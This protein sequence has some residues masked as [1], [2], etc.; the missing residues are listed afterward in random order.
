[1]INCIN[2]HGEITLMKLQL[3][4]GLFSNLNKI[5]NNK[6]INRDFEYIEIDDDSRQIIEKIYV[7]NRRWKNTPSKWCINTEKTI[8]FIQ[9]DYASSS[10]VR[11]PKDESYEEDLFVWNGGYGIISVYCEHS[12]PE[13]MVGVNILF[14]D[15]K[16]KPNISEEELKDLLKSSMGVYEYWSQIDYRIKRKMQEIETLKKMPFR[17]LYSEFSETFKE[18]LDS[19]HEV[20]NV[21]MKFRRMCLEYYASNQSLSDLRLKSDKDSFYLIDSILWLYLHKDDSLKTLKENWKKITN[22]DLVRKIKYTKEAWKY[23]YIDIDDKTFFEDYLD[24][25]MKEKKIILNGDIISLNNE[26]NELMLRKIQRFA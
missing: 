15:E 10:L 13:H 11:G 7:G 14:C 2:N 24:T 12:N 8:A 9:V 18:V 3:D 19:V 16:N 21:E 17:I 23:F 25:R 6:K 26:F 20:E 4:N 22:E 5:D 1:M